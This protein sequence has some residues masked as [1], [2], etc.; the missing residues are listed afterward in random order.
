MHWMN[1][2]TSDGTEG[3]IFIAACINGGLGSLILQIAGIGC[4]WASGARQV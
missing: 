1:S 4:D 2:E 3:M